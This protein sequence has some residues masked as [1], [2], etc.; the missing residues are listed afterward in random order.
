MYLLSSSYP[1]N[2]EHAG[3]KSGPR[4]A[5]GLSRTRQFGGSSTKLLQV[6]FVRG[7]GG[8][9]NQGRTASA[10]KKTGRTV[11][12]VHLCHNLNMVFAIL[13][14]YFLIPAIAPMVSHSEISSFISMLFERIVTRHSV[15]LANHKVDQLLLNYKKERFTSAPGR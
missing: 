7:S 15:L 9:K 12:L 11:D 2:K 14:N 8:K 10:L 3:N 6:E 13:N 5:P 4:S 1:I